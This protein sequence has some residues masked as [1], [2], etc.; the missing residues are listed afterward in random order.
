MRRCWVEMEVS[1]SDPDVEASARQERMIV[2]ANDVL[3]WPWMKSGVSQYM[4]LLYLSNETSLSVL[5]CFLSRSA[6]R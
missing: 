6:V 4:M 2:Q 5:H 1:F 3:L